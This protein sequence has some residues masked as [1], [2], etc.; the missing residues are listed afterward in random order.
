MRKIQRLR[1]TGIL[2]WIY[3]LQPVHQLH[4][5][6]KPS[7]HYISQGSSAY[8]KNCAAV[9][10][11]TSGMTKRNVITKTGS[12]ISPRMR[13]SQSSRGEVAGVNPKDK[14]SRDIWVM[15]MLW[16]HRDLWQW[17]TDHDVPTN[18]SI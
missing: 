17:L 15:R 14:G 3:P 13:G 8:L 11:C 4:S 2:E 18:E 6:R 1:E 9:L 10:F 16:P 12:L 7:R 5:L